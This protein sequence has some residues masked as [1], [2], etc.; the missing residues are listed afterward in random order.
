MT[1]RITPEPTAP[2]TSDG[3]L[4]LGVCSGLARRLRV[5]TGW[6]RA[7]ALVLLTAT[8]V[9]A[10]VYGAVALLLPADGEEGLPWRLRLDLRWRTLGE[11]VRD[12]RGRAEELLT[13]WAE[14]RG[15][16]SPQ[17]SLR[18]LAGGGLLLAGLAVFLWSLPWI[19][20]LSFQRAL[21]LGLALLGVGLLKERR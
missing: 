11:G 15:S 5:R 21:G 9:T 12:A 18:A 19:E 3:P 10:L 2:E 6:V 16:A 7:A 17:R 8:W 14:G 1:Q 13:R 4:L 20:W